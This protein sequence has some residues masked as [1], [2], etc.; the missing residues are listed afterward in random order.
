[1]KDQMLTD[2]NPERRQWRSSLAVA[3][4]GAL[5]FGWLTVAAAQDIANGTLAGAIRSSD[6]PC[7]RVLEKERLSENPP[8]WR[9]RCNSGHYEV[10]MKDD[11]ATASAVVSID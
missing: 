11:M 2:K 6:Q 8:T 10:T 1:M 5:A 4:L 7:D 3:A 9:V